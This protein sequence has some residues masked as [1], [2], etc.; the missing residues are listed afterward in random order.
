M[1]ARP[2]IAWDIFDFSSETAERNSMKIDR[3][4]DLN[5]LAYWAKILTLSIW[6]K[7]CM[8]YAPF[9]TK[10]IGNIQFALKST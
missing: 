1:A 5:V 6:S 8:S 7:F 3:K 10:N 2:L 4:E 9:C